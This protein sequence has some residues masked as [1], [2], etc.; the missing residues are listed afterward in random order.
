MALA[1]AER[2]LLALEAERL[3]AFLSDS[4]VD[5][6][7]AYVSELVR[8]SKRMNLIGANTQ[9]EILERHVLDSLAPAATI[10]KFN[11][12]PKIVDIGSGAGLP[13]IPLA[14]A[15]PEAK[16]ML[17]EPRRKRANFL[18]AACR[19]CFTW[20]IQVESVRAEDFQPGD[21]D[22]FDIAVSRAT[23][24]PEELPGATEHLLKP[25]GLLVGFTTDRKAAKEEAP[26]GFSRPQIS[27]YQR[28]QGGPELTLTTWTRNQLS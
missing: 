18:R 1:P 2:A 6:M 15:I 21:E 23:V 22:C 12:S 25:G 10:R 8:W 14:I 24:P 16:L 4:Q 3:G 26:R 20:N 17:L 7:D 11:P 13:G 9:G 5:Q 28:T 19:E 27:P